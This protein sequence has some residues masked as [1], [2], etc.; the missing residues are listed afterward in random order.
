MDPDKLVEIPIPIR[1]IP[2]PDRVE[3]LAAEAA[4]RCESITCFGYQASS[5]AMVYRVLDSL[6]RGTFCEWGSGM[7]INTGIA[8][9]LGF[10]AT[11]IELNP[12]LA[13]ASRELLNDFD[14]KSHVLTGSYLELELPADYY[15][16]YGW[17]GE[18]WDLEAHFLANAPPSSKL[19]IC[20]S[21]EKVVCKIRSG[22]KFEI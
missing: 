12:D 11:G 5:H 21:S 6:P 19:L 22:Y 20:E 14:L 15:Y 16:V 3:E 17:P 1:E 10:E 7:G 2:I 9:M 13:A 8:A 4:R 18:V